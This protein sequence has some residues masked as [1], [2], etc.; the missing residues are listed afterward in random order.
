M[1][2][3]VTDFTGREKQHIAVI[4]LATL[5]PAATGNGNR[6]TAVPGRSTPQQLRRE[7]RQRPARDLVAARVPV[8]VAQQ[9]EVSVAV[10][11]RRHGG[12]QRPQIEAR[13]RLLPAPLEQALAQ[14]VA[15]QRRAVLLLYP[16]P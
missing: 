9:V 12:Q 16:R 15:R 1:F 5:G 4:L 6:R 7:R 13:D 14:R 11:E 3:P 8:R 2:V 10:G